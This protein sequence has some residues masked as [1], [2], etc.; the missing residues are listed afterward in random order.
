MPYFKWEE[1]V[2]S[3]FNK[4][5]DGAQFLVVVAPLILMAVVLTTLAV[6]FG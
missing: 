5:D 6:I 4:L 2:D 1:K 3:W